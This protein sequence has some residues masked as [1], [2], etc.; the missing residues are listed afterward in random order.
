MNK[1]QK[2]EVIN[3][4]TST[5]Q[6]I[7]ALYIAD[8]TGLTANATNDL[9]RL[10]FENGVTMKVAKN[11]LIKKAMDDSGI[12]F[13]ELE[14]TL[15]GNSVIMYAENVKAP[16]L[17]LK[18]FR[19]NSGTK[20]VLKG[21]WIDSSVYLGDE[22]LDALTKLKSKEDLIGDVISL[23]QSPAKNVISGLQS[24]AGHKLAALVKALE[25]RSN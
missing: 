22:N 18:K 19:G 11:T 24:N 15:K 12:D 14:S 5:F 9:R 1:S 8:A 17:S 7:N 6:S 23:L 13:S 3:E 16:A 20:P 25:E 21:A 10:M 2:T 4:L